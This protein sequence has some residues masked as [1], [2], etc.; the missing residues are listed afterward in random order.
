MDMGGLL[1]LIL[2]GGVFLY[3]VW[4]VFQSVIAQKWPSTQGKVIKSMLDVHPRLSATVQIEYSY[5]VNGQEFKSSNSVFGYVG[6]VFWLVRKWYINEDD[7][8]VYYN[9][10]KPNK[11]VLV[12]GVRLFFIAEFIPFGLLYYFYLK[13][14]YGI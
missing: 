11:A 14:V 7:L 6:Y 3:E 10:L 1:V 12:T 4:A 8:V 5:T 2:L 9:P 13:P